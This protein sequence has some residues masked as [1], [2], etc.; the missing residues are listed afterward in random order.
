M[1]DLEKIQNLI[2]YCFDSKKDKKESLEKQLQNIESFS[3]L[4]RAGLKH[5]GKERRLFLY[6]K[7]G[8]K[9]YIQYPGKETES[10]TKPKPWDFRPKAEK[11]DNLYMPDLSFA[12]IWDDITQI[13]N[14]TGV[15]DIVA[16]IFFRMAYLIDYVLEERDFRYEDIDL[17][18][19]TVV[20][21][22]YIHF[23]WYKPSFNEEILN[24]LSQTISFKGFSVEAYL[25]YNDLLAQNEDCKYFYRE[26]KE[27]NSVWKGTPGRRNTLL[28][29]L[30]VVEYLKGFI[31]FSEI[32]GRFQRG[33]GVAPIPT[34]EIDKTTGNLITIGK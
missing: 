5:K 17:E 21:T 34:K 27:K 7:D 4:D 3:S 9:V 31:T 16:A 22:G 18:H 15:I 28:S 23:K 19:N 33:F 13:H 8:E 1:N 29:H 24:F 25:V 10:S 26:T 32:M 30:S 2:K 6:E 11:D 12:D 20:D 14:E